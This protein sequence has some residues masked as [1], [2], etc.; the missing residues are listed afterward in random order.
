MR[1]REIMAAIRGRMRGEAGFSL[2]EVMVAG[3]ILSL[4]V[5]PMVGLF[6]GAYRV[7]MA[8]SDINLSAECLQRYNE[9]ARS[10]PFYVAHS[11]DNPSTPLDFDDFYWGSRSPITKNQWLSP[12]DPNNYWVTMKAMNVEPYPNMKVE[13]R[14]AFVDDE[15]VQ[16]RTLEQAANLTEMNTNWSPMALYGYDRPKTNTGKVLSLILYEVRVTTRNGQSTS[17]TELYASPTDMVANVYIDRV[18]NVSSD[19]TKKGTRYNSYSECISAPHTKNS[20]TI[21]AYG[22][23]FSQSDLDAGLVSVKLVRVEDADIELKNMS[24]GTDGG[25]SYIEGTIDLNDNDGDEEPWGPKYRMPGYWHAWLVVNHVISVRNNIF[26]VEYPV[27]VYHSPGSDFQDSDGNKQGLESTTDEV[28]TFT[29]VDYVTDLVPENYPNPGIGAVVQLVHT[30]TDNGVPIDTITGR[31]LAISPTIDKGYRTGLTVTVHFDFTGHVGG[32]YMLRIINC[33]DRATPSIEV[34]GNTYLELES[35]PYYYLEGPPAVN[36]VYVYEETPVTPERRHFVYDDRSYTYTLEIKGF[37]FDSLIAAADIKLGIGGDT[38]VDPPSGATN[39]ISPLSVQWLNSETIRAVFDFTDDGSGGE[40]VE[41]A[42]RGV[43][44]IWVRNSNG[45]GRVLTNAMD[46]RAPAPIIYGYDV[47]TYGLWQNYYGVQVDITG[48]CFDVDSSSGTAFDVMIKEVGEPSN[49]WLATEAM[50]DPVSLDNGRR[51][52]CLLNLVDCDA[53]DWELY[54]KATPTGVTDS[55]Y[56]DI[57]NGVQYKTLLPITLGVPTLLTSGVPAGSEP[58][59]VKVKSHY[60]NA[61]AAGVWP[62][63]WSDWLESTEGGGVQATV[64]ETDD[65]RAQPQN[66]TRGEM[67]FVELRGMG[68][69]KGTINVHA[70]NDHGENTDGMDETWTNVTVLVDRENAKVWIEMEESDAKRTGPHQKDDGSENPIRIRIKNNVN[71][72]WSSWFNNR[73]RVRYP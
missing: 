57:V 18:I 19:A 35:G 31:N 25:E 38:S 52:Q 39:E 67:F 22:E 49:D 73:I 17:T 66:R 61:D 55:G 1:A 15:L 11:D 53:G 69:N 42:E 32:N 24:Y 9:L 26:V 41:E 68:F 37:N 40:A 45:F 34:M 56:T 50:E 8:A 44:W 71:N 6:D 58:W 63:D 51:V 30:T 3:L 64:Y 20:I 13:I 21:R 7:S 33:I 46:I 72:K 60:M 5:F 2:A 14:M 59:S 12:N 47:N 23:G 36:E 10:V 4:A 16:G 48:E 65:G 70:E 29:M 43:Y 28:L 54:G 62:E 27:P